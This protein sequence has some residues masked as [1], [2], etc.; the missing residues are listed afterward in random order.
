MRQ[1]RKVVKKQDKASQEPVAKKES[2]FYLPSGRA[3][4]AIFL[5]VGLFVSLYIPFSHLKEWHTYRSLFFV[6]NEKPLMATQDAYYYLRLTDDLINDRYRDID[7][8]RPEAARPRPV[9]LLVSLTAGIHR[10]LGVSTEKIA[11]YLPPLLA[12]LMAPV[13]F[14]WSR[15]MGSYLIG[16]IASIAGASSYYWYSRTCLGRFDTDALNPFF[17]LLMSY[18]L[19]CF[20]SESGRKR[21]YYL[22]AVFALLALFS[23]W[24]IQAGYLS[25]ILLALAYGLSCFL[26]SS[27]I[28]KYIKIG[29]LAIGGL[30]VLCIVFALYPYL[31]GPLFR[32]FDLAAGQLSLVTK[33]TT[34]IFPEV[35]RSISEL[36]APTLESV[37]K[38]VSGHYVPFFIGL[39]GLVSLAWRRRDLIVLLIPC[40]ALSFGTFYSNRF[41]IFFTPLYAIGLGYFLGEVLPKLGCLEKLRS[42][43]LKWCIVAGVASA[44]LAPGVASSLST[45]FGPSNWSPKAA[46]AKAIAKEAPSSG[47]VWAWWDDG[48]FIQYFSGRKTFIDGGSQSPIRTYI[49]AAPLSTEDPLFARRWIRF[50]AVRDLPG[51]YRISDQFGGLEKAASFLREVFSNPGSVEDILK[52]HGLEDQSFWVGFLFPKEPTY[53]YLS[54]DFAGKAFWWYYFGTWNFDLKEGVHPEISVFKQQEVSLDEQSGALRKGDK[55][56][57]LAKVVNVT[58]SEST[59]ADYSWEDGFVAIRVHDTPDLYVMNHALFQSVAIRL[60]FESP[61]QTPGF[62]PVFYHP[63]VGGVWRVE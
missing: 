35:G 22:A 33:E 58:T 45:L 23:L 15:V 30:S 13:Y 2:R 20:V 7:D 4:L 17:V 55:Y 34:S 40:L 21:F 47:S 29:I 27:R 61:M 18:A 9:P 31:P 11:F 1:S 6:D 52:R 48:Y 44:L 49:A 39:L 51:L 16:L 54:N 36:E 26:S 63:Q 8:N 10:A 37:A 43:I 14:L 59:V 32:L 24:W 42:S 53:L 5:L 62:V 28:E 3:L 12:S 19:Y 50:F 25:S 46:M 38:Q 57:K 56:L 60:L 41:L